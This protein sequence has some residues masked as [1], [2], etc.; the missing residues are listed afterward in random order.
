M[1]GPSTIVN[2]YKAWIEDYLRIVNKDRIE[3]DFRLNNIQTK[4]LTQDMTGRDIILKARQQGFS[5]L[6]LAIF[7]ADFLFKRNSYNVVMADNRDNAQGLLK[8][9]KDYLKVYCHKKKINVTDLLKYNNKYELYN[10]YQD[11][12]YIIG[13]A[14]NKEVGRS[15][16]IT[17]LHLSE[18]AFYP[19]LGNIIAST[20]QAVVPKGRIIIETTANG[21]NEFKDLWDRTVR[22]ETNYKAHFYGASAFYDAKFLETKKQELGRLY[23]QEY[24]ETPLEA[25]ITSGETFFSKDALEYYMGIVKEPSIINFE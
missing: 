20:V 6:V 7:T 4:F 1:G 17:N 12:T 3:I 5:S 9:V 24:P 19:N 18:A 10:A 13:T 23:K 2:N 16:T 15:K 11:S 14:E 22:G 25:F 8:R 21:F